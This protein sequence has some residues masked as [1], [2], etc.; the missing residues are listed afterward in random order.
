[1]KR[2]KVPRVLEWEENWDGRK[3]FSIFLLFHHRLHFRPV[4]QL[5]PPTAIQSHNV[6]QSSSNLESL[7]L[8]TNRKIIEIKKIH[9]L[10]NV[11]WEKKC[12]RKR[13]RYNWNSVME[14]DWKGSW[15][16]YIWKK[17]HVNGKRRR[18]LSLLKNRVLH[19]ELW[20]NDWWNHT[21]E[22]KMYFI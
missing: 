22:R 9:V 17:I 13:W 8:V 4:H 16:F 1:M 12:F 2:C 6:F 11:K 7:S 15:F 21:W 5:P 14:L 3:V 18:L 10:M 20:G 19:K